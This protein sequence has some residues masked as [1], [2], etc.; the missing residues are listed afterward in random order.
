VPIGAASC[1]PTPRLTSL[2]SDQ[3]P[4]HPPPPPPPSLQL[5]PVAD[6]VG[7][8]KLQR[9]KNKLERAVEDAHKA[10]AAPGAAAARPSAV[11]TRYVQPAV[12]A[13]LVLAFWSQPVAALPPRWFAPLS[14]VMR[15]PGYP[16]GTVGVVAW[17]ALCHAVLAPAVKWAAAAAGVAAAQPAPPK[18]LIERATGLL[19]MVTGLAGRGSGG[20]RAKAD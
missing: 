12:L 3:I 6:F 10:R 9:A 17:V 20:G 19:S 18:S 15:S 14:W 5:S 1:P 8:S 2:P 4:L 13:L 16:A 11:L 7:V